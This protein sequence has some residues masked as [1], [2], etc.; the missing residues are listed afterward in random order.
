MV[1]LGGAGDSRRRALKVEAAAAR[2][3]AP[4]AL[5]GLVIALDPAKAALLPRRG[6]T[7]GA[8]PGAGVGVGAAASAADTA[9]SHRAAAD[10]AASCAAA[11]CAKAARRSHAAACRASWACLTLFA[12]SVSR[13]V[14]AMA[15][16]GADPKREVRARLQMP[17]LDN[18]YVYVGLLQ[19]KQRR[20]VA[21]R[22]RTPYPARRGVLQ[23]RPS[24]RSAPPRTYSDKK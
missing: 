8:V 16:N 17:L 3:R 7:A 22:R 12:C 14:R 19:W 20:A 1:L 24:A 2:R 15:G 11:S 10:A 13:F 18:I 9:A 6:S 21:G 4:R 23:G 5:L